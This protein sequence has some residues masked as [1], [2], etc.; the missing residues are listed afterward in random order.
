MKGKVAIVTGGAFGIGRAAA[1][2]FA[3]R[4]AKVVVAD[5]IADETTVEMIRA[6]GGEALFVACDVLKRQ[7]FR[8]W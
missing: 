5:Y 3:K 4:G 7:M 6:A 1:L 2:A 8:P